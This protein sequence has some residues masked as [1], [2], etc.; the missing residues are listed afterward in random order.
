M[1]VWT[2][3]HKVS[4][5][6]NSNLHFFDVRVFNPNAP[7]CRNSSMASM[8]RRHENERRAYQQ[9]ILGS[10]TWFLHAP[11]FLSHR[12]NGPSSNC[13]IQKNCVSPGLEESGAILQ[14]HRLASVHLEFLTDSI[15]NSMHS[16]CT[17][18]QTQAM[19]TNC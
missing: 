4:G 11:C 19:Q 2:S 1:L 7:S 15:N 17:L 8:Y 13:D 18:H 6:T 14:D 5:E 9:R 12:W 3:V 10:G 16:W